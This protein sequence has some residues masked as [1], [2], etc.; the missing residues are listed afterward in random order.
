MANKVTRV[1]AKRLYLEENK[2]LEEIVKI[3]PDATLSTLYRWKAEENWDKEREEVALTSF[4]ATKQIFTVAVQ[5]LQEM[6]INVRDGKQKINPSEVYALRQLLKSAKEL[7][8]DVDN[9]GNIILAMQEFTD[10]LSER[11]SDMLQRLH[12]YLVEFG[13]ATSKKYGKKN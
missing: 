4:A 13:N 2:S 9:Y 1:E 8:K 10:F 12:P 6:L 3:L 5:Q 7:Q 11:D